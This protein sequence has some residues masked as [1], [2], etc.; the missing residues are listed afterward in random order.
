MHSLNT[1]PKANKHT[2]QVEV[3]HGDDDMVVALFT[4][5]GSGEECGGIG[6]P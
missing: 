1:L 2:V 5:L 6:R 4:L 3:D